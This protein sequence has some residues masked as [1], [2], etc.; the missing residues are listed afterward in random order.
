MIGSLHYSVNLDLI[1]IMICLDSQLNNLLARLLGGKSKAV[2]NMEIGE[3]MFAAAEED[4]TIHVK[5]Q[6]HLRACQMDELELV[7]RDRE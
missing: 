3:I 1:N 4:S 6:C 2:F 7:G 5:P